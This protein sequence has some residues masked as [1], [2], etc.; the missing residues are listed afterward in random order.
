MEGGV[1][2]EGREGIARIGISMGLPEGFPKR[3]VFALFVLFGRR[4]GFMKLQV[5]SA[6][7]R[8]A[9]LRAG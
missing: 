4:V 7:F 3:F 9:G 6:L 1:R 8:P 2:K 5:V